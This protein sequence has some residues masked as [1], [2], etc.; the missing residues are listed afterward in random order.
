M[1]HVGF[2]SLELLGELVDFIALH[3]EL[4]RELLFDLLAHVPFH[5]IVVVFQGAQLAISHVEF[6]DHCVAF[7][8]HF[9]VNDHIDVAQELLT[10]SSVVYFFHFLEVDE[11]PVLVLHDSRCFNT[12][13]Q[14]FLTVLEGLL[15]EDRQAL[16]EVFHRE[17][18]AWAT[19]QRVHLGATVA[20]PRQK[21]LNEAKLVDD[22]K[23]GQTVYILEK[24]RGELLLGVN[25]TLYYIS[26]VREVDRGSQRRVLIRNHSR[27]EVD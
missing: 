27:S 7:R 12:L 14:V 2:V 4:H 24:S 11:M 17:N 16:V 26:V 9:R 23:V 13:P 5:E 10:F 3:A 22:V 1:I 21:L 19:R 8:A 25:E 20:Q 6:V 18:D 15:A